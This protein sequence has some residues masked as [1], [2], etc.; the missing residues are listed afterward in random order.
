M[1]FP[2][3]VNKIEIPSFTAIQPKMI[4]GGEMGDMVMIRPCG[5]EYEEKTFIGI[6]LGEVATDIYADLNSEGTLEVRAYCYNPAIFVP[7]VNKIIFGY[8]SWWGKIENE[9]QLKQI[10]DADIQNVWYVKVL[11]HLSE[12]KST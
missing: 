11:K 1:E 9:E 10:T 5:E 7:D 4:F 8:E 12:G 6:L 2:I 3:T